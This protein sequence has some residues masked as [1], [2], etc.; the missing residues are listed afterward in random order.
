MEKVS[1]SMTKF[2][3]SLSHLKSIVQ[4]WLFC[5]AIDFDSKTGE[6]RLSHASVAVTTSY[7]CELCERTPLCKFKCHRFNLE[8]GSNV[9]KCKVQHKFHKFGVK[10]SAK[11]VTSLAACV[12][13]FV[14]KI[15][16]KVTDGF[17]WNFQGMLTIAQWTDDSIVVVIWFTVL[18]QKILKVFLSLLS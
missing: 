6:C 17:W 14:C 2:I 1:P 12:C 16:G 9:N 4:F 5:R 13:L 18:Y 10:T 7:N 15:T 3:I 11:E 8:K